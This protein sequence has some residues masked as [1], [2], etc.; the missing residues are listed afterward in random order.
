MFVLPL[1]F[2]NSGVIGRLPGLNCGLQ[3]MNDDYKVG[4]GDVCLLENVTVI[5]V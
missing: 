5:T 3:W 2:I 4:E 1:T